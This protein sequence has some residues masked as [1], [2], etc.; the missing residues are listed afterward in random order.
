ML[1]KM[2]MKNKSSVHIETRLIKE[3]DLLIIPVSFSGWTEW[4]HV[5]DAWNSWVISWALWLE[6]KY[7]KML[8]RFY[9]WKAGYNVKFSCVCNWYNCFLFLWPAASHTSLSK[10]SDMSDNE[11]VLLEFFV[12]LPQLKQVTSDKEELVTSIVNMA[13]KLLSYFTGKLWP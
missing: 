2:K 7:S 5:Q 3:R 11:D 4:T 1:K 12:T 6:V 9:D 13:S 8:F 10:L